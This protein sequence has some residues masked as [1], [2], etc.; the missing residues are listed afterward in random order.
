ME[1]ETAEYNQGGKS[2]Q[3]YFSGFINLWTKYFDL[4]D[5]TVPSRSLQVTKKVHPT[6]NEISFS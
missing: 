5:T 4:V 2:I 1:Y 6:K 3:V